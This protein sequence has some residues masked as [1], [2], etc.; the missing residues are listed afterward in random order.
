MKVKR[1]ILFLFTLLIFILI[2]SILFFLYNENKIIKKAVKMTIT[3][4]DEGVFLCVPTAVVTGPSWEII[5]ETSEE[6]LKEIN[7]KIL[8]FL[9]DTKLVELEGNTPDKVLKDYIF[10]NYR[11]KF[12]IYGKIVSIKN[13]G[14]EA[15]PDYYDVIYVDKWEIVEPV[16]RSEYFF[17][18]SFFPK[19]GLVKEDFFIDN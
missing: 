6:K 2:I 4:A 10:T 12:I 11:N 13:Y 8:H 3:K 17:D 19:N 18:L 16:I 1:G 15:Y 7:N 14:S 5:L 9:V